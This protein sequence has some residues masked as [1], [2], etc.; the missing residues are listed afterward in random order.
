MSNDQF[1]SEKGYLTS[2]AVICAL[3]EKHLLTD[4]EYE[5]ARQ[6]LLD[7]F[8]PTIGALFDCIKSIS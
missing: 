8:K 5:S 1:N 4:E 3:R 7:R 2:L 6:I